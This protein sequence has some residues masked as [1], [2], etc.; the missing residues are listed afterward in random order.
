MGRGFLGTLTHITHTRRR[1]RGDFGGCCRNND[2]EE[3]KGVLTF[4]LCSLTIEACPLRITSALCRSGTLFRGQAIK[5]KSGYPRRRRVKI[6]R[7][8][9]GVLLMTRSVT[10]LQTKKTT[11]KGQHTMS[12]RTNPPCRVGSGS[13]TSV[14]CVIVVDV[15]SGQIRVQVKRCKSRPG[16]VWTDPT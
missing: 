12:L 8:A 13:S 1:K 15:R 7:F 5:T 9:K 2:Y 11:R 14:S 4:E 6:F 16:P 10:S 3:S